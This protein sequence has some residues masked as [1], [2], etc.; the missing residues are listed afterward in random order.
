MS[1]CFGADMVI[2]PKTEGMLT[3]VSAVQHHGAIEYRIGFS[4]MM[5]LNATSLQLH[6][7]FG[8]SIP[9]YAILSHTWEEDEVTLQDVT[10][11]SYAL[12]KGFAKVRA[13]CAQALR[14]GIIWVWIDTCCIDKTSSAD[15]SE[16]INSMF[17]WY[18]NATVCY[19]YLSD[20]LAQKPGRLDYLAF[21][22]TKWFT[23]GWTLQ[24]LL[25]PRLI[26]F[27]DC[28]WNEVGTKSS[29]EYLLHNRTGIRRDVLSHDTPIPSLPVAERMSWASTRKTTRQEDIA[30]CLLG[31]FDIHMP[32][33]YGE[34]DRAFVRLQ[35]EIIRNSEDMSV[36]LWAQTYHLGEQSGVLAQ[37]PAAFERVRLYFPGDLPVHDT[38]LTWDNAKRLKYLPKASLKSEAGYSTFGGLRD[39]SK[40]VPPTVTSRGLHVQLPEVYVS[41][42]TI[43]ARYL[44]TRYLLTVPR[45]GYT[46]EYYLC[47]EVKCV[48]PENG[49]YVRSNTSRIRAMPI[50]ARIDNAF[51]EPLYLSMKNSYGLV[52]PEVGR[53]GAIGQASS[54]TFRISM[55]GK[56]AL[57]LQVHKSDPAGQAFSTGSN[58]PHQWI[59]YVEQQSITYI[60]LRITETLD[61]V[62]RT[63]VRDI[64]VGVRLEADGGTMACSLGTDQPQMLDF[65]EHNA[66]VHAESWRRIK[67]TFNGTSWSDR[68]F[69][70]LSGQRY[71]LGA[72]VKPSESGSILLLRVD[73]WE[74][75]L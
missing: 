40:T 37:S 43:G 22:S 44:W 67:N 60:V 45:D 59:Y 14:D 3:K 50:T 65:V 39:N 38:E 68:S 46:K 19:V 61:S 18:Q 48:D 27:Y 74:V 1:G 25:A 24:E 12:K 56:H 52:G 30:Y 17:R 36:L 42:N 71:I 47:V 51:P 33:L 5:L 32:L 70:I 8:Y 10:N 20:L 73:H 34:G 64:V 49:L 54:K 72:A 11:S 16:A 41:P 55:E 75:S 4:T 2:R 35:Q 6:E 66:V 28:D 58:S 15:L 69:Q 31:I 63:F 9:I 23:R 7:F 26:E 53:E 29:L 21:K 57:A 62:T 13:C